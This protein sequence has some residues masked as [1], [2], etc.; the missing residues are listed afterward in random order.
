[1]RE[2]E[3]VPRVIRD[4]AEGVQGNIRIGASVT[5]AQAV[6]PPVLG[7]YR[8]RYPNVA[9]AL[10]PGSSADV[11][12]ALG[13]GEVDLAFVGCGAL[14]PGTSVVAEI[15]DQVVFIAPPAH[16]L[17]GRRLRSAD[18]GACDFIQR[19]ALSDTRALID[20]W[21]QA[22]RVQPRTVMEVG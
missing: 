5:A 16:L 15:P 7:Q 20:R 9:L 2:A 18:L 12:E 22:E 10:E 6:L 14:P 11:L 3:S 13:R 21:F 17:A 4:L 8:R 1:M 19:D